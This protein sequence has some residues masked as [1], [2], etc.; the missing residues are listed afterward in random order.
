MAGRFRI[1]AGGIHHE[2]NSFSP[3]PTTIADFSLDRGTERYE[4]E[5]GRLAPFDQIDLIPT[6][7]ANAQPG[8]AV[9]QQTYQQLK[10]QLLHEITTALPCDGIV[11]DL[12]GAMEVAGIGDGETDLIH[13]V[14]ALVGN[15]CLLAVSLD[16]HGNISPDLVA[17]ANIL[18]AY[19]TAPHRDTHATR[20]RALQLLVDALQLG[21]RPVAA[22][23]KLPLLVPG[24]AAV[25]DEEPARSLYAQ[26]PAL[27]STAGMLDASLLI[28]CAWTD[29]PYATVSVIVVAAADHALAQ[30]QAVQ[31]AEIVWQQ[32][33]RFGYAVPALDVDT[34]IQNAMAHT[35]YPIYLSD[36]GDNLTAGAPGDCP[37]LLARLLAHHAQ[38]TLVAGLVDAPVRVGATVSLRLGATLDARS[39]PALPVEALV[40]DVRTIAN[41]Q[42][43]DTAIIR[44]GGVRVI[45]TA[46]RRAF[47][48]RATM[49]D[50]GAEPN[51][52]QLIVV[53]LGYLFPDLVAHAAHAILV[54]NAG[55][56]TL[57]LTTLPYQRIPRPVFP[58]DAAVV[59]KPAME[60]A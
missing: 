22:M 19:R 38:H 23:V 53:K 28:G 51:D 9:E 35:T 16:L 43:P 15:D 37:H 39:G 36:S 27:A 55:A 56:T 34:A 40:E 32:R 13:A 44:I 21:M 41:T 52:Y 58:L 48:E 6:F 7:V 10:A 25:T 33:T 49:R 14:R 59:W 18:T 17:A 42:Q 45:L 54:L 46:E 3:L 30:Q 11:L 24:E 57:Q 4:D 31:F 47:T 20:R 8:G 26:L 2:T 50:A 5:H 60:P 12:H 1:I 29:S